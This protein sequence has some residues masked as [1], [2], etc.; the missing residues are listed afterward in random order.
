LSGID[1]R[2]VGGGPYRTDLTAVPPVIPP[3][4]PL[5]P[6]AVYYC[7]QG[8]VF[9]SCDRSDD[10]GASVATDPVILPAYT[11]QCGGLH[12]HVKV[13]PEGT[14]Y[15]PNKGCG[16]AQGVVV[17]ENNGMNWSIRTVPGST[18]AGS[19]PSVRVGR[20]DQTGG[21]GRVYFGYADGDT[22]A[23]VTTST[24]K[25]VTWTQ[26]LDVGAQF[27]INNV[28]FPAMVAGDDN[29]AA[30]AFLGTPTAGGLQGPKFDGVWHL[31]IATT[32]DGGA[33]WTGK[34]F[35]TALR[36]GSIVH[37]GWSEADNGGSAITQY[38]ILRGTAPGSETFL[39]AVGGNQ[40][41]YDD[42]T[43]TNT[44]VTY[45]YK[46]TATNAV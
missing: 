2:T 37:L 20:G 3:P 41:R 17:S 5:Y 12:G 27:G 15:L 1:H 10:G 16:T 30:F 31:Y 7:S 39:A 13:G 32:Y 44:A 21:I 8:L 6:N 29:R 22:K 25:G 46:V 35:L 24:N 23:V 40:T 38:R 28:V 33:T 14:V 45:Y 36:N 11:D 34:P 9:A 19:D 18:S 4:H 26:P 42:T 43:A